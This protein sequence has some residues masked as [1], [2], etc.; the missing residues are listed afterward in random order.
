[1][2]TNP[3]MNSEFC[4]PLR[5]VQATQAMRRLGAEM[6]AVGLAEAVELLV[7]LGFGEGL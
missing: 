4:L 6:V 7:A 3:A 5:S 1:M 2:T